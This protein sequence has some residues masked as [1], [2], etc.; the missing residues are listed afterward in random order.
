MDASFLPYLVSAVVTAVVV[1]ALLMLRLQ[2]GKPEEEPTGPNPV[3]QQLAQLA[4]MQNQLAGRLATLQEG[5]TTSQ[6]TLNQALNERL[7]AVSQRLN[8]SLTESTQKTNQTLNERLEKVSKNLTET[9]LKNREQLGE[10]LGMLNTRL[11]VIGEAQKKLDSLTTEVVGLQEVLGNKQ[12]RGAFGEIQLNDLVTSALPPS[13][14]SFQTPL[15]N[16][17]R[18][19]CLIKLPN[20]PGSIAVDSKFPLD[21]Y[22]RLVDASDEAAKL[23]ATRQLRAD[24]QKHIK[25]I[26][27]KYIIPGETAESALMFLPSEAVYAELHARFADVVDQGYKARV[28]IVSP[29]TLMAT[30]NTVRAVLKDAQM[31]E[32]AHVI[33]AEVAKLL[34]DVGRLDARVDK[35][36]GHF[37]QAEKDIRDIETSTAKITRKGERIKE[38]ELEDPAE[39]SAPSESKLQSGSKVAGSQPDLLAGE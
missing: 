11:A 7:D 32:Q 18:P 23:A 15:S 38:V 27:E 2:K 35:L 26:S 30:L 17:S 34:E 3:E 13:A 19:D 14:Y 31:R 33:Q 5:Q 9:S 39:L 6:Q 28:W 10:Q 1:T 20:P 25:D 4:D 29:T 24:V 16:K 36:K 12:A 8:Q 22:R 37:A 21:S